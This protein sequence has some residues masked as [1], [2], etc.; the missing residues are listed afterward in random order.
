MPKM[1]AIRMALLEAALDPR[2]A[3]RTFA[4]QFAGADLPVPK[5]LLPLLERLAGD[6][7][8]AV[9]SQVALA[10]AGMTTGDP[11]VERLLGQLQADQVSAVREAARSH[12]M[13]PTDGE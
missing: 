8:P 11:A 12:R 5:I 7:D 2:G 1:P 9:R 13:E 10:V 4:I 3:N 6:A